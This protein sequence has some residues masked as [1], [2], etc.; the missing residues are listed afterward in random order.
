MRILAVDYGERWVGL[1][2]SDPLHLTAQ[3]LEAHRLGREEENR[4]FFAELIARYEVGQ[5]VV[6]WP[7]RMN[8]TAGTQAQQAEGFASWLQQNFSLPVILW[9]ER[10]TTKQAQNLMHEQNVPASQGKEI[11][12][13]IAALLILESYLERKRQNG[14]SP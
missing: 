3:P 14:S 4:L 5:I 7:L 10:L 1:A 12:H 2:I 6:G 13:V 8:G 9:D 11:E